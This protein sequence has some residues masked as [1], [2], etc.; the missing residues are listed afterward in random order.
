MK[1]VHFLT[2]IDRWRFAVGHATVL[3]VGCVHPRANEVQQVTAKMRCIYSILR[4]V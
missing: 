4:F 1:V 3:R 2:K